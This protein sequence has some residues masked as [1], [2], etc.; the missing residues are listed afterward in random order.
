MQTYQTQPPRSTVLQQSPQK[1]LV[2]SP[3]R[4]LLARLFSSERACMHACMHCSRTG[5]A[6]GSQRVYLKILSGRI[7]GAR[8]LVCK[9]DCRATTPSSCAVDTRARVEGALLH[10]WTYLPFNTRPATLAK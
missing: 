6:I 2:T 4:D 8:L 10:C 5:I 1:T 9:P 3:V 7:G